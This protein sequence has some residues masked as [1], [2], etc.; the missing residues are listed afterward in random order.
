M[1]FLLTIFFVFY[2]FCEQSYCQTP[3]KKYYITT[4]VG[5]IQYYGDLNEQ[6]SNLDIRNFLKAKDPLFGLS[7]GR[8]L[9]DYFNTQMTIEGGY[10]KEVK[11]SNN[12]SATSSFYQISQ[13]IEM[14]IFGLT[15][16]DIPANK[17]R[18]HNYLYVGA[19]IN[20]FKSYAN[21]ADNNSLLR[22]A[23]GTKFIL[24]Y[25]IVLKLKLTSNTALKLDF[26]HN[27]V[28]SD[29][30]DATIGGD[31]EYLGKIKDKKIASYST[32]LDMWAGLSLGV[33]FD[34]GKK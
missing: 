25:G 10:F 1:K 33:L 6:K 7:I 12:L 31:N 15:H 30:F 18:F 3:S 29:I 23:N 21:Q 14:D 34:L 19:G 32:A 27:K 5:K 2:F 22:Q 26:G 13:R 11:K 28:Y 17:Q 9:N 4:H 24:S 8:P 16:K 20:R